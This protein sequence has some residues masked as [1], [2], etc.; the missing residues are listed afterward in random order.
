[1]EPFIENTGLFIILFCS[2]LSAFF[3]YRFFKFFLS[4][5][6]ALLFSAFAWELSSEYFEDQI[7][8]PLII[9]VLADI[10]GAWL[11]YVMFKIAAFLY[12]AA[13]GL[14]FSPVILTFTPSDQLWLKWAVPI[15]CA[16][17]GGLILLLSTRL[18]IIIM[19]AASGA[20]YFTMSFLLILVNFEVL[21][22]DILT[23]PDN[24]QAGLWVLCFLTCFFSGF[25]FQLQGKESNE[26]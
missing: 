12:G 5:A 11:F 20:V 25:I 17:A 13:A 23:E 19:T 10:F 9:T 26:T 8:L 15:I 22:E 14:A 7:V 18:V 1:M 16:L 6:G 24:L 3:G 4:L 21:G 2:L